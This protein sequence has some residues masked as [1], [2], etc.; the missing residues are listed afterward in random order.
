MDEVV[1]QAVDHQNER[2]GDIIE[3]Y[4]TIFVP[5]LQPYALKFGGGVS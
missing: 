4:N 3:F 5:K 2:R 1:G